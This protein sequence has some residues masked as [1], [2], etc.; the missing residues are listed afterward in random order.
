M[1]NFISSKKN[2]SLILGVLVLVIFGQA[3]FIGKLYS[4]KDD[5]SYQVNLVPVKTEKDSIDYLELKNNL[6]LVDHTV[7]ELNSFLA[8]KNL[9]DGKIEML[10]KDSIS[11]T[12]YLAKQT[13]RYSQYLVDLQKK[14]QQVP[15]GIPTD[16]YISSQFGKRKNP[17]PEKTVM[18]ASV[19][20]VKAEPQYIEVKDSVGNVTKKM[21]VPNP[22][23]PLA[24]KNNAPSEKDQMKFHK[25]LDIAVAHGS[26]VRSAASGKV[27][28]AGEKS[29]YGNC[30]I[31]SHGNGL[32]TLYG[33]L[34][35]IL[36]KANDVVTVNDVIAKSG[37]TGRSTGPHLHY[38]VHKNNT[39]VNPKFFMNL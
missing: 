16:G 27:I 39:P 5:K 8:A 13:N 22:N 34:S 33:H 3:L 12:V 19:H 7:R 23:Q 30:V 35:K 11:N 1:K 20:S 26:D 25:G 37:N 28:F 4:E 6:T 9:S 18:L 36:V 32:D 10:A 29:G 21:I 17:F 15:L 38:E 14:L 24:E 2:I 31:I